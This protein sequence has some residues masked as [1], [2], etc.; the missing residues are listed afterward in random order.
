VCAYADGASHVAVV[1]QHGDGRVLSRCVS[2]AGTGTQVLDAATIQYATVHFG[3]SLGDAVC[4]VDGEPSTPPGG[5]TRD[6]CLGNPYWGLWAAR[7]GGSWSPT[8]HGVT[9]T[10]F[11]DGDAEGLRYGDGSTPPASPAGTCPQAPPATATPAGGGPSP[12]PTGNRNPSPPTREQA[13]GPTAGPEP[14]AAAGTDYGAG[15]AI[16]PTP[17]PAAS[18]A[19][20][21]VALTTQVSPPAAP[22]SATAIALA[23][24]AR[25][26]WVV[27]GV[28]AGALV[29]LLIGQVAMGRLRR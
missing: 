12:L 26:G 13:S 14:T 19:A 1:V 22:R 29:L 15:P 27:A 2:N 6:N 8:S 9:N 25:L 18:P 7:R 20:G 17:S 10:T 3:G 11:A 16:S 28:A 4:Q 5:F 23:T 21:Y 24:E